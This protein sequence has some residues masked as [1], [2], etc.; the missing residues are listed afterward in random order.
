MEAFPLIYFMI[1]IILA[2]VFGSFRKCRSWGAFII[3]ILFTPILGIPFILLFPRLKKAYCI[4]DY[5]SFHAGVA[6]HFRIEEDS[7]SSKKFVVVSDNEEILSEYEFT[8]YFV[9]IESR[10]EYL[11]RRKADGKTGYR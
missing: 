1:L 7:H 11:K 9:P 3:L 4:K 6:Y 2:E 5:Q 10:K 8:E